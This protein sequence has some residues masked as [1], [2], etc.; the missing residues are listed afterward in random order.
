MGTAI[1]FDM[2][3]LV[4]V[5]TV[6]VMLGGLALL[7]WAARTRDRGDVQTAERRTDAV[8]EI[9][10]TRGDRRADMP[11]EPPARVEREKRHLR[12]VA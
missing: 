5:L 8:I 1:G 10:T 9:P 12:L 7:L 6:L 2:P 11:C 4:V 3:S